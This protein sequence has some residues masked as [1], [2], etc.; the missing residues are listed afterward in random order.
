MA[1]FSSFSKLLH[2]CEPLATTCV[3]SF[4]SRYPTRKLYVYDFYKP[5]TPRPSAQ[6]A[7]KNCPT[8]RL[9][10]AYT[11]S[12]YDTQIK[13]KN[14][15][16]NPNLPLG[17]YWDSTKECL[18]WTDWRMRRDVNRRLAAAEYFPMRQNVVLVMRNRLL[19]EELR[20]DAHRDIYNMPVKCSRNTVTNRCAIT[21]RGRG[22]LRHYRLSR[23]IWRHIADYNNMSGVMK[24]CWGP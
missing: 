21:S 24:S 3:R 2:R 15:I 23:I 22:K 9:S 16:V 13:R 12:T 14:E 8:P 6:E 11:G 18:K 1:L 5:K 10:I 19:P 17:G 7:H 20:H 4:N